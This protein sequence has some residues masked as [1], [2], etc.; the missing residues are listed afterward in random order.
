M[1]DPLMAGPCHVIV[2]G[3]SESGVFDPSIPESYWY[4]RFRIKHTF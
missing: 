2:M 4:R 1:A 3:D